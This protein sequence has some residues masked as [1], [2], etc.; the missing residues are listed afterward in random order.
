MRVFGSQVI[1]RNW[2]ITRTA[3]YTDSIGRNFIL[4]SE[5]KLTQTVHGQIEFRTQSVN[6]EI[7][8]TEYCT[9]VLLA[10]VAVFHA[11]AR[12]ALATLSTGITS[13]LHGFWE[14][15]ARTTRIIPVPNCRIF[16]IQL[17][18]YV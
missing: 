17:F 10:L 15:F 5:K 16:S 1:Y 4:T 7:R 13:S 9:H 18:D 6:N 11:A 8:T 3:K 14:D 12:I 2:S